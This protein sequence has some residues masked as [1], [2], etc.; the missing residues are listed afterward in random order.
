MLM[1]L[2]RLVLV[3]IYMQVVEEVPVLNPTY[4]YHN[5]ED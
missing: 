2:A 4:L 3:V 1:A 5:L